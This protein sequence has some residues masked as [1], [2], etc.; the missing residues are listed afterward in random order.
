MVE[1]LLVLLVEAKTLTLN[2][3]AKPTGAPTIIFTNPKTI[4]E[5]NVVSTTDKPSVV[6]NTLFNRE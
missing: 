4:T 5:L 2:T 6:L 3:V 1:I